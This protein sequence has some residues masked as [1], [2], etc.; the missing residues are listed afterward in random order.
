MS[1]ASDGGQIGSGVRVFLAVTSP[2]AWLEIPQITDVK[3]PSIARSKI[4]SSVHGVQS[5][6]TYI[7]GLGDVNDAELTLETS[8]LD[9][10]HQLLSTL[11]RTQATYW[12]RYQVPAISDLSTTTYYA[13]QLQGRVASY[14]IDTPIDGLKTTKVNITF[15]SSYMVQNP[16]A[17]VL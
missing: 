17:S 5:L 12:F 11:E 10:T 14:V 1:V 4:D 2:H 9:T 8:L 16:M 7:P 13:V 3:I 6:K 15:V